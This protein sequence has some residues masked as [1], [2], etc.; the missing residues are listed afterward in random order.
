MRIT[1]HT[2][3]T[4]T[5]NGTPFIFESQADAHQFIGAVEKSVATEPEQKAPAKPQ[6]AA[7]ASK[8]GKV[9]QPSRKTRTFTMAKG[10]EVRKIVRSRALSVLRTLKQYNGGPVPA[11][12]LQKRAGVKSFREIGVPMNWVRQ[13]VG[14]PMGD[15]YTIVT[16]PEGNRWVPGPLVNEAIRRVESTVGV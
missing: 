10:R 1:T 2:A 11:K 14:L 16:S 8:P 13:V 9:A 12:V 3:V 15:I 5:V 7:P 4:V 6:T